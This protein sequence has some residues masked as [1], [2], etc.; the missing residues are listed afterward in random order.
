MDVGL[1][2]DIRASL[3]EGPI[4]D[5]DNQRLIWVDIL[6][7]LVHRYSPSDESDLVIDIGQPVSSLALGVHGGMVC[8][9]RDGFGIVPAGSDH[10]TQVIEVE[11]E[12]SDNRMNDGRCDAAGRFWAGTMASK[13]ETNLGAGSLY[14]LEATD[15]P[16]AVT[17]VM[18]D[19]SVANGI[20]WTPDDRHMYYVD[21][22]T[23]R[24]DIFDFDVETGGITNRRA[25]A[26]IDPKH[27]LPDGLV[28]DADGY[29]WVALFGAGR[30]R[31]YSPSGEVD[32]E[33]Q[34]PVTLVTRAAFGGPDL[35]DLYIT[36]AKHRLRPEERDSQIHAGS[37]FVCRPGPKGKPEN[38]FG[39]I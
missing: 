31:R 9:I 8:A 21:S 29:V 5:S 34:L 38:R 25:F 23:Q 27:G 28:V 4:W 36:T 18:D 6:G 26:T 39:W 19:V 11:K 14:R 12:L 22:W 15:G 32:L 37:L 7:G 3:G 30:L 17:K 16:L 24:I 10:V 1:V 13:W 35:A 2:Q 33:I 20:D